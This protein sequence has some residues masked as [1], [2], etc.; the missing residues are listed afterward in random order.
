MPFA[1]NVPTSGNMSSFSNIPLNK[2]K[3]VLLDLDNTLYAYDPCHRAASTRC[4]E[5][6]ETEFGISPEVFTSSLK[7]AR[8][9]IHRQLKGQAA[10]HSRLLYFHQQIENLS[11]KS[12]PSYALHMEKIYWETFL[13]HMHL[14]EEAETFLKSLRIAKLKTCLVTD[15][16]TQIQMQKWQHLKL[17]SYLDFILTSE[18]AGIEKP[19][20]H[21]FHLALAKLGLK[22]EEVIMIGDN[23]DKDIKGAEQ[24]GIKAYLIEAK[25]A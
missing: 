2:I 6:A 13:G 19:A 3:G 24:L 16:T 23:P 8:E 1:P 25:E 14:T 22:P 15:L 20:A 11:G 18:E 5:I 12:H 17:G 7:A 4:R 9:Q 10:S 21:I